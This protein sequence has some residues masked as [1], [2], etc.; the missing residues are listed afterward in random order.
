MAGL[1]A[2]PDQRKA[3]S[4]QAARTLMRDWSSAPRLDQHPLAG[5]Q[6]VEA[7]QREQGLDCADAL[8]Q[9]VR[10]AMDL[11]WPRDNAHPRA[12]RRRE[13]VEAHYWQDIP[14]KQLASAMHVD[15]R[16]ARRMLAEALDD[17]AGALRELEHRARSARA[18]AGAPICLTPPIAMHPLLVG[19]EELLSRLLDMIQTGAPVIALHGLPGSG[20]TALLARLARHSDIRRRFPDG[21]LW[22]DLSPQ[23]SLVSA[24]RHW[25]IAL[26]MSQAD[27]ARMSGDESALAGMIR[28]ALEAR[29]FLIM[30]NDVSSADSLK[31]LLLGGSGCCHVVATPF[32]DIA[33]QLAPAPVVSLPPLTPPASRELIALLIPEAPQLDGAELDEIVSWC[34]GLPLALMVVGRYLARAV[35]SGQRRRIETA[36]SRLRG[37]HSRPL[38][39]AG[40]ADTPLNEVSLVIQANVSQLPLA[41]RRALHTL[42]VLP[43]RPARFDEST[44]LA[45]LSGDVSSLDALVDA[46]LLE[47]ADGWYSLH[48]VIRDVLRA[49]AAMSSVH[50]E[51]Q[52]ALVR[53]TQ[54]ALESK[55]QAERFSDSERALLLAAAQAVVELGLSQA[56]RDLARKAAAWLE[57][58]GELRLLDELLTTARGAEADAPRTVWLRAQHARVLSRLGRTH[59]ARDQAQ[60]AVA[61]AERACPDTLPLALAAQARVCLA[62]GE[63]A[64]A[65]AAC[66]RALAGGVNDAR[67]RLELLHAQGA[68]LHNAGRYDESRGSLLH[69][70]DLALALDAAEEEVRLAY[71]LGISA[72]QQKD[73]SEA[74]R[75]LKRALDRARAIGMSEY[76][77][78]I[79]TTLGIIASEA[80]QYEA[81][82]RWFAEAEGVAR[83][84]ALPW[85]LGQLR[86]AQGAL[87]M[88]LGRLEQ[89]EQAL[90]EALGIAEAGGWRAFVV[91]ISIEL[92]EC[93]LLKGRVREAEQVCLAAL[94]RA[95][96]GALDDLVAVLRYA[97]SRIKHAQ[98]DL[99]AARDLAESARQQVQRSGHYRAAE[100][101]AWADQLAAQFGTLPA[102][103]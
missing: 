13:I 55:G 71:A 58:W 11:V 4:R 92:A 51:G 30:L 18:P 27:L 56:A 98:D 102:S 17:L 16:T 101:S 29:R 64:D 84:L 53:V 26:G 42:S 89:A 24:L 94:D 12:R 100:V 31:K 45:V 19:R 50:H 87:H 54:A 23:T 14:L 21:V 33:L 22:A 37:S 10:D 73:Y 34:G 90:R 5:L 82:E 77:A 66:E 8:R 72:R 41:R 91:N 36:L 95:Q 46:G 85:P 15:E 57:L 80:G 67:L 96:L 103:H 76:L 88:R 47:C 7:I 93:L 38:I 48:P 74:D 25:A 68:V 20:K 63:T 70:F 32:P 61:L 99:R 69:A 83:R 97:L 2:T 78:L 75:W 79:L 9:T 65:L 52:L 62:A 60:E 1:N 40:G 28:A 44:L 39:L 6:A 35:R 3:I 49:D 59:A 81:A 86:H 43:P